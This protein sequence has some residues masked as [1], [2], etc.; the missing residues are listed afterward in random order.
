MKIDDL[1]LFVRIADTESITT[2]AQQLDMTTA[3]ASAALK[4][5]E[6]QLDTQLFV[7]STRQLRITAEGERFLQYCRNALESVEDGIS[8]I[9]SFKGEIGGSIRMSISSDLGRN[10]VMPWLDQVLDEHPELSLNIN[11]QDSISDFYTDRVDVAIRYGEPQESTLVAFEIANAETMICASPKYVKQ[12]GSPS[13][14]SDLTEHNCLFYQ[15]DE[16]VHDTWSFQRGKN[17]YKVHVTGNRKCNDGELVK[18]WVLAGKGIALK[19]KLDMAMDLKSGK[20]VELLKNYQTPSLGL[21]MICP[22]RKQ[23][24]PAVILLRDL[25]REKCSA[26]LTNI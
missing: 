15:L 17:K 18:R 26:L 14:P 6:E 13:K 1:A 2:S 16:R 21:W 11:I 24:T 23:V 8:A 10:I 25:F 5:L 4:R 3:A 19:S 9:Q 22:S 20:V 7:R 12:F